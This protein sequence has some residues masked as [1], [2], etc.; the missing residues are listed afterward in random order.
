[1]RL[2]WFTS[3]I[4]R[5]AM[6]AV[7]NMQLQGSQIKL[8]QK[9]LIAPLLNDCCKKILLI[10]V[11]RQKFSSLDVVHCSSTSRLVVFAFEPVQV[12]RFEIARNSSPEWCLVLN[13]KLGFNFY[14][15]EIARQNLGHTP[16]HSP[17]V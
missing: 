1:M 17:A 9:L 13:Q 8:E 15:F 14:W 12:M 4:G 11:R 16:T 10:Y 2:F 3:M 6:Q 7:E 5:K